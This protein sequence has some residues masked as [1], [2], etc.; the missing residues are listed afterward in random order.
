MFFFE[1]LSLKI[2]DL[3]DCESL[4]ESTDPNVCIGRQEN[5]LFKKKTQIPGELNRLHITIYI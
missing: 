1:V 3:D 2:F 5:D 4:P